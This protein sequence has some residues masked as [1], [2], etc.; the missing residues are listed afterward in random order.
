MSAIRS[1]R[2]EEGFTLVELLAGLAIAMVVILGAFQVLD[3]S[4]SN[5]IRTQQRVDAVQR[6]RQAMDTMTRE[7]RSQVCLGKTASLAEGKPDSVTFYADFTDGTTGNPPQRRTLTFSNGTIVEKV[8]DGTGA[9]PATQWLT[10]P[11]VST[12]L[13]DVGT[14]ASLPA[15]ANGTRPVFRYYS[16]NQDPVP[17][18]VGPLATPLSATDLAKVVKI[19]INFGV[20]R[21]GA[22]A[23]EAPRTVMQDDVYI[24]SAD[25]NLPSPSPLCA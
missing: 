17:Q 4:I 19:S 25:P 23:S 7:L 14:D 20:R 24:R 12:L 15:A 21:S 1:L 2:R 3:A 5:T 8:E 11:R 18:L 9:P 22:P 16:F 13:E 10:A 6:G